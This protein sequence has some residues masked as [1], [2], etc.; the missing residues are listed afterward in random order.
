MWTKLGE[1]IWP[2]SMLTKFVSEFRY[3]AATD[4]CTNA[5]ASKLSDVK[6][7]AKFRPS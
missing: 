7:D 4:S 1:D 3:L 2:S 5:G 6:N